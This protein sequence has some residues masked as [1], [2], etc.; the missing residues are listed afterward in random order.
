MQRGGLYSVIPRVPGGEIT[1]DKLVTLGRVAKKYGLYTKITGGQRVDLFGAQLQQ[2][3]DIWEEL[4][5]AGFESGHAYGKAVRTVKSCV[6]TTWCRYGVQDSVGFAI[7]IEERYRGIR[8]PHKLK[9]AVSGCV[10]E[11]AEAQCKDVGLVATENGYNLYV[12]GNGGAKPR[13]ADLLAADIDEETA[14]KYI[15]RFLMYYIFTADKLT[16]TA[17]WLDKLKG[18]I[19]YLKQIIIDDRLGI[20]EELERRMQH[21]VDTYRCEWKE[22][23]NNPERRRL[24]RQFMNTDETEPS[25]ELV[26]ER[27]QFRPADWPKN[28]MPLYQIKWH[29]ETGDRGQESGDST[30]CPSPPTPD[31]NPSPS[32]PPPGWGRGPGGGGEAEPH[33]QRPEIGGQRSEPNDTT[34]TTNGHGK[35]EHA[36][37]GDQWIRVGTTAD[38][39]KDGGAAIKYGRVQIAVFNFTTRGQWY[40]CQNMCPHK[41]AFVLSRGIIGTAGEEPK[42]ACPLHKKPYSL[43]TGKCLSGEGYSVKV[44]PVKVNGDAVFVKLPPQ[45]QLDALLATE[46]HVIRNG[47]AKLTEHA[48]A[49]CAAAT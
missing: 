47:D 23:V 2:L 11:C 36:Q 6:G 37:T 25:I 22:V 38:F 43:E 4:V 42:V 41:N 12:C 40:A 14:I 32:P 49:S 21:L 9:L 19:D 5:D 24:F 46:L 35:T 1:P 28:G 34:A 48:C 17:V 45:R 29:Q 26:D 20:C 31:S 39:P 33:G 3:P 44:F 16:R 27:G 8:A 7:R 15:D 18:G 10:R 13:H 30:S